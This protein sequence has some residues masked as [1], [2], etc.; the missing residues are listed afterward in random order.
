[1]KEEDV[2]GEGRRWRIRGGSG[3]GKRGRRRKLRGG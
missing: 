1:M 3:G 2:K